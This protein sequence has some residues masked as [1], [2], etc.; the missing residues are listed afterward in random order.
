MSKKVIISFIFL[1]YFKAYSQEIKSLDNISDVSDLL[2]QSRGKVTLINFWATWCKPCVKEFPDLIKLYSEYKD[3]GF[4]I[5][6]ISLD[7]PEDIE[8]KVRT[9]L[10]KNNVDFI[11]YYNNFRNPEEIINYI[12]EK[13]TGAIPATYIY[14]R[15]GLLVT[16]IVGSLKY[17][18]FEKELLKILD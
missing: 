5:I 16:S 14:N 3:K 10:K 6:F 4:H 11:T 13:W 8:T 1:I 15:D 7:V 18:Q 2:E 9:F 17:E 12:D